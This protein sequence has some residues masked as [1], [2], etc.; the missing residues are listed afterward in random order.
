MSTHTMDAPLALLSPLIRCEY[1]PNE[2]CQLEY[3]LGGMTPAEYWTR[4]QHGW[5]RFGHAMFRPVCPSCQMCQSLRVPAGSFA[6]NRS[7]RRAWK[8]NVGE[9]RTT[10]ATPSLSAAKQDLFRRFHRA[11]AATK[12]WPMPDGEDALKAL[13]ANPFPTEEW[14]YFSGDRL[15]AVGYVDVL[16][17][18]LSAIYFFYDPEEHHRSLGTLNVLAILAA[19]RA[20]QLPHVYLGYYVEGCR[21]LEYKARFRPNEV[22]RPDGTWTSFRS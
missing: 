11:Q 9:I 18:G 12:G 21:S 16:P 15:V 8:A 7:Q 6:P 3:T 20:R 14:S 1:L 17:Q 22:Y 10:I 4:L 5:R 2:I 13:I 19:A